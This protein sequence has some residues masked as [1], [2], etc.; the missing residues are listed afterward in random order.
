MEILLISL[1]GFIFEKDNGIP[2][3]Y[4]SLTLLTLAGL[5]PK[6]LNAN[7]RIIDETIENPNY[8]D[9]NPDIV[10]ISVVTA[11]ADKAEILTNYF[12]NKGAT[13]VLGGS[14][15]TLM[16]KEAKKIADAVVVGYAEESWPRLLKDYAKGKLKDFYYQ[17]KDFSLSNRIVP[18]RNKTKKNHL[19]FGS[20]IETTR[21]C[22]NRCNFC[23]IS[24]IQKNYLKKPI[25]QVIEEISLLKSKYITF[26]D[27]NFFGDI[28]YSKEL[29]EKLVSLKKIWTSSCTINISEN[30][31]MLDL[32]KKSGCKGVL[33]GFESINSNS[34]TKLNKKTNFKINYKEAIKKFHKRGISILGTF[35]IGADGDDK[36]IFKETAK[37]AID[38][39][40]LPVFM[41]YTPLP[42]TPIFKNMIEENRIIENRLSFYDYHHIVFEPKNMSYK[43]LEDGI[44][45]L[46]KEV[47][48][49][50]NILKRC[51]KNLHNFPMLMIANFSYR[52]FKSNKYKKSN[53]FI[54]KELLQ[55]R[56]SLE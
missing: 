15:P 1:A 31:E 9:Y 28:E 26:L 16:P 5:I 10:G 24:T 34:L 13:V 4:G 7:L 35:M 50:K 6:E 44:N 18:N 23:T 51:F 53:D 8:S 49:T 36:N 12:K 41:I 2:F 25:D 46:W 40:D 11:A 42:G 39:I 38:N 45:Y 48:G 21:G 37:F 3:H 56:K 14:Y 54:E 43:D 52:F 33:I 20:V 22:V 55:Y 17:K 47:Y 29:L 19:T 30:E 27:S 32:M